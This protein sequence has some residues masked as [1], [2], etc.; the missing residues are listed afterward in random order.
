MFKSL[1]GFNFRR[2]VKHKGYKNFKCIKTPSMNDGTR[3]RR[4]DRAVGLY[5]KFA[6]NPRMIERA[7]FQDNSDFPLQIQ[8]NSQNTRVYSKGVNKT[9]GNQNPGLVGK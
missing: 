9:T 5:E 1:Q 8:T 6:S 4:I 3:K 2:M 7:V